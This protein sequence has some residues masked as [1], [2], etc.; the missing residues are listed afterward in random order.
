M[1]ATSFCTENT[2]NNSHETAKRKVEKVAKCERQKPTSTKDAW[3][4][5]DHKSDN[6]EKANYNLDESENSEQT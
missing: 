4:F 2:E 6:D 1:T 5:N 3:D